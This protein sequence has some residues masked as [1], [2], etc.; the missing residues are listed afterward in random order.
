MSAPLPKPLSTISLVAMIIGLLMALSAFLG[1]IV[2]FLM[3]RSATGFSGEY[4]VATFF[5]KL[6]IGQFLIAILLLAGGFALRKGRVWG[7]AAIQGVIVVIGIAL[8]I[9]SLI[10]AALLMFPASAKFDPSEVPTSVVVFSVVFFLVFCAIDYALARFLFYLR[11]P[12]VKGVLE[13]YVSDESK[14]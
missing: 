11:G 8:F 13:A 1:G 14:G 6:Y 3:S 12:K 10:P 2:L 9:V 7:L 4:L 5:P